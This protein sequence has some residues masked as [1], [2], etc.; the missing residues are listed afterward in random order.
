MASKVKLTR[1]ES[2]IDRCRV[3]CNWKKS[4]ELATQLTVNKST[5]LGEFD[6]DR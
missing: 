5:D 3:E 2:E 4:V 6:I 1:L